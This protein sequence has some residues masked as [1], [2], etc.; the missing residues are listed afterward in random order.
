M[1][2][3]QSTSQINRYHPDLGSV[4]TISGDLQFIMTGGHLWHQNSP[5]RAN[6]R[7]HSSKNAFTSPLA[8][9]QGSATSLNT[10]CKANESWPSS[11][12]AGA[13][14]TKSIPQ[15]SRSA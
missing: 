6:H 3:I 10:L 12:Q 1:P 5:G 7:K 11:V 14:Q 15:S 9:T 13:N 2:W 4:R 8:F